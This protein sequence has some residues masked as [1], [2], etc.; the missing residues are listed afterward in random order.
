MGA[1]AGHIAK[2]VDKDMLNKLVMYDMSEKMLYRDQDKT[3]EVPV[4]RMVGDEEVLPF[5]ANSVDAIISSLSL[6]WVNDIP[7]TL[8]QAQRALKPDGL[9]IGAMFGG[10]TL[11]EL[12]CVERG[13][14][15][16][17]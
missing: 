5:E 11:Y 10:E 15:S 12:R 3:Y 7:G 6:H 4:E 9:F 1:G 2:C 8:I 16:T 14:V 13:H 17:K